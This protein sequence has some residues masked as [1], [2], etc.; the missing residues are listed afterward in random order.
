MEWLGCFGCLLHRND[1]FSMNLACLVA[2]VV[3][4]FFWGKQSVFR[5][6]FEEEM[7]APPTLPC[8]SISHCYGPLLMIDLALLIQ[9][10]VSL[11]ASAVYRSE[12]WLG[13]AHSPF[14][15]W[16]Q[17]VHPLS[18][19]SFKDYCAKRACSL[20]GPSCVLQSEKMSIAHLLNPQLVQSVQVTLLEEGKQ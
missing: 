19:P 4:F 5:L 9:R 6:N 11:D 1:C 20:K 16:S 18:L 7:E 10:L 2:D 8:M 17:W 13:E 14:L 3:Y 15:D 12:L